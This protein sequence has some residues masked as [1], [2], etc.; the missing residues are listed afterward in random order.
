MM[1]TRNHRGCWYVVVSNHTHGPVMTLLR[2]RLP[3][4]MVIVGGCTVPPFPTKG[5]TPTLKAY[6][7]LA[8]RQAFVHLK[9]E[10]GMFC[11]MPLRDRPAARMMVLASCTLPCCM[12]AASQRQ[13]IQFHPW[14]NIRGSSFMKEYDADKTEQ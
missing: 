2:Q 11:F 1:G 5:T 6:M 4:T 8:S 13:A 14:P 12:Q 10:A 3:L 9:Y 7:H